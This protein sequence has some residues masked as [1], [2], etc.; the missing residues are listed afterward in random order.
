MAPRK[1]IT[2]EHQKNLFNILKS[3]VEYNVPRLETRIRQINAA[4]AAIPEL[5]RDIN[6]LSHNIEYSARFDP[7]DND[8]D[9][10]AR[11]E[12]ANNRLQEMKA[13]VNTAPDINTQMA[14]VKSFNMKYNAV[15]QGDRLDCLRAERMR[16]QSELGALSDKIDSAEINIDT[17]EYRNPDLV[18]ISAIELTEYRKRYDFIQ[19][20]YDKLCG[21]ISQLEKMH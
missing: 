7:S 13:L 16:L 10:I 3:V 5:E 2:R 4:G 8:S 17:A 19:S 14:A 9:D 18:E 21:E 11:L 1:T 20:T 6:V 15:M 12:D